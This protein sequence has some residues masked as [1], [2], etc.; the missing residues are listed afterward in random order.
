MKSDFAQEMKDFLCLQNYL[1]I[2]IMGN[3]LIW[4]IFSLRGMSLEVIAGLSIIMSTVFTVIYTLIR[5]A[6]VYWLYRD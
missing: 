6:L 3:A 1:I 2:M 4:G 5:I